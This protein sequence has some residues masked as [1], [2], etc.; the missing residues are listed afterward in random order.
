MGVAGVRK[1]DAACAGVKGNRDEL[2]S[3]I[4]AS[5]LLELLESE[6]GISPLWI[7]LRGLIGFR[8]PFRGPH[9]RRGRQHLRGDFAITCCGVDDQLPEK[10]KNLF[11]PHLFFEG[12]AKGF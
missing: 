1:G 3:S 11:A 7:S 4:A 12:I 8:F 2:E 6:W 9:C 5:P 10:K